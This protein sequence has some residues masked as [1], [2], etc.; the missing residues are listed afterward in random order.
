MCSY[1]IKYC[2][3]IHRNSKCGYRDRD[4]IFLLYDFLECEASKKKL[5]AYSC[6]EIRNIRTEVWRVKR[7]KYSMDKYGLFQQI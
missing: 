5:G 1:T 3:R 6:L 2:N 4:E 7:N